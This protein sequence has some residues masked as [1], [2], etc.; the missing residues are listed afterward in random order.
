MSNFLPTWGFKSIDPEEFNQNKY[1]SNS[2]KGCVLEVDLENPIELRELH[3]IYLLAPDKIEI[4]REML[5]D[6]IFLL[7]ILKNQYLTLITIR[8]F[9]L[10]EASTK[11]KK[12]IHHV[13][14]FNQSQ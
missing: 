2:S 7:K 11:T 12:K 6:T 3:N 4:K 13:L 5:Y 10:P 1:T 8:M 9:N 14:E